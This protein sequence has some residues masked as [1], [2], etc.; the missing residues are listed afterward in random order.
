MRRRE[1]VDD[2]R[3][4]RGAIK[5]YAIITIRSIFC[6]RCESYVPWKKRFS[7]IYTNPEHKRRSK[8]HER[9]KKYESG[10]SSNI[11]DSQELIVRIKWAHRYW[12]NMCLSPC[13]IRRVVSECRFTRC[14]EFLTFTSLLQCTDLIYSSNSLFLFSNS[15]ILVHSHLHFIWFLFQTD[16]NHQKN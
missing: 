3:Q 9:L 2:V 8:E 4:N 7:T 1:C 12:M 5:F 15:I 10:R 13:G 6:V 11:D 14:N 16:W